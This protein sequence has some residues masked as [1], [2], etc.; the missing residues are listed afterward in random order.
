MNNDNMITFLDAYL[1]A[2]NGESPS[3]A[4]EKQE[5]RGQAEVVRT[6]RLPKKL[7][8]TTLPND[9]FWQGVT[10]EMN[11]DERRAITEQNNINYTKINQTE[12]PHLRGTQTGHFFA[13]FFN[14]LSQDWS[15]NTAT[16]LL[17]AN[18][19]FINSE[20]LWQSA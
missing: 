11:Y 3:K 16:A 9:V 10:D 5:R 17:T 6:Q 20:W 14:C 15:G 1:Y 18:L 19:D 4:I 12:M 2:M 8:S 7:N 13:F